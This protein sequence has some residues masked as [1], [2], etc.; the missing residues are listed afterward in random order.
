MTFTPQSQPY[1]P[2]PLPTGEPPR[3]TGR[4]IGIC[5]VALLAIVVL[6]TGLAWPGWMIGR[7]PVASPATSPAPTSA[8]NTTTPV[9]PAPPSAPDADPQNVA[10]TY[11]Q[12]LNER[13]IL[14]EVST[15]CQK[16]SPADIQKAQQDLQQQR[17]TAKLVA[18][19]Q[20]SGDTAIGSL[21]SEYASGGRT[22]SY[23]ASFTMKNRA[24]HWCINP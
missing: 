6:V 4:W 12:A 23:P 8:P 22:M 3:R 13:D 7:S 20:V 2:A 15:L 5:V 1:G 16:P 11:V 19:I 21:V 9:A 17:P 18:P 14:K 24:G 10:A